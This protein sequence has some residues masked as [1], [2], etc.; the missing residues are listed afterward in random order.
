MDFNDL[1]TIKS[2]VNQFFQKTSFELD[3]ENLKVDD[4]TIFVNMR[5]G[6]P[7][8]LIGQNGQ[9]LAEIQHLL[10][11]VLMRKINQPFYINLDINNYKEKKIEYLKE[12]V[13]TFANDVALTSQEKIL[14]PMSAYERRIIHLELAN[15]S[16]II[17]ESIGEKDERRLVIKP[18]IS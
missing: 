18:R 17:T 13:K 12:I 1:E 3:V 8:I 5:T 10:K 7:K 15:R 4:Q 9:T 14:M 6:D 2:E 11:R 16:D